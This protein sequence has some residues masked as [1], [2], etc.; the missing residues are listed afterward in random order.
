[1]N[2]QL[3]SEVSSIPLIIFLI[4]VPYRQMFSSKIES[5]G[6]RVGG[7]AERAKRAL[8]AILGQ[9]G[10]QRD[11][12]LGDRFRLSLIRSLKSNIYTLPAG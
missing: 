10:D 7:A 5:Q 1:M 2:F 9:R 8:A 11:D 12:R 3:F 4:S 6:F